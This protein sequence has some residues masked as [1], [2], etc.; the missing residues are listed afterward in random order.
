MTRFRIDEL[1]PSVSFDTNLLNM[2]A[3]EGINYFTQIPLTFEGI[4][5]SGDIDLGI[6]N[7]IHLTWQSNRDRYWNIFYSSS[8]NKLSPF[9]FDTRITNTESNSLRPTISVNRNGSRLIA[10]HDDRNGN[11]DI[12]VAR[13]VAGYDCN[14]KKCEE[15][16]VGAFENEIV[17]CNISIEYE[18]V[19][20]TYALSLEFYLDAALT[21][22]YKSIDINENNKLRWFIDNTSIIDNLSYDDNGN[23]EGIIFS[24]DNTVNISY[25]PNQNDD[26]FDKILYVKLKSIEV[27]G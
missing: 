4:N 8:V 12:F 23:I 21:K 27:V 14:Y 26:I 18:S 5:Q 1:N 3:I 6:C 9:R 20:G 11:Y 13:S 25:T 10:W 22:L 7:D 16:M 17:Q 19:A 24:I 2:G 15:K